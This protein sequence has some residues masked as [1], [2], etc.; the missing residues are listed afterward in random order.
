MVNTTL[1]QPI[2]TLDVY[3]WMVP[4]T[5]GFILT[6]CVSAH[7]GRPV[8]GG[9][10]DPEE[11]VHLQA[12]R[13]GPVRDGDAWTQACEQGLGISCE[14]I[15]KGSNSQIKV[16]CQRLEEKGQ[17]LLAFNLFIHMYDSNI[18]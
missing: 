15:Q 13:E 7:A 11:G 9:V 10:R 1:G 12:G 5:D 16:S 3:Y 8:R 18:L 4:L 6:P 17:I 14:H 2:L